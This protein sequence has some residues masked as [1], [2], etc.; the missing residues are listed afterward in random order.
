MNEEQLSEERVGRSKEIRKIRA[1]G[2]IYYKI[3]IRRR[4]LF[5]SV[6]EGVCK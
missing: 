5:M 6:W 4:K 3:V 2:E 1:I